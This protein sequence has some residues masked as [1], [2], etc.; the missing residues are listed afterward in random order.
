MQCSWSHGKAEDARS[1]LLNWR[2][3]SGQAWAARAA[4]RA[5]TG[6]NGRCGAGREP[7]AVQVIFGARHHQ[8]RAFQ[9]H[10]AAGIG[11]VPLLAPARAGAQHHA[12]RAAGKIQP[13]RE[14]SNMPCGLASSTMPSP[15]WTCTFRKAITGRACGTNA[16]RRSSERVSC[17]A[18]SCGG[19]R[20]WASGR[21]P[22]RWPGVG[23]LP[24]RLPGT[25]GLRR[26]QGIG[27]RPRDAQGRARPLPADPNP[28]GQL[29]AECAGFLW[30]TPAPAR[31]GPATCGSSLS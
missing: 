31:R 16:R 8:R 14:C 30:P 28:A 12:H 1:A 13:P 10:R 20:A 23:R 22:W 2:R 29:L 25:R 3:L 6:V 24:P 9:R 26:L 17:A 15:P 7:V 11:A 21:R 5:R 4:V 19:P 18:G 27:H